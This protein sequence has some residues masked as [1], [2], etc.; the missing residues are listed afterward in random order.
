MIVVQTPVN[1]LST[2]DDLLLILNYGINMNTLFFLVAKQCFNNITNLGIRELD[3]D[4]GGR[5]SFQACYGFLEGS[6]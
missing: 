4:S 2:T 6:S 1:F 5:N 3:S